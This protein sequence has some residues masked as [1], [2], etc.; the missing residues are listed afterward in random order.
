MG[1]HGSKMRPNYACLF[2]GYVEEQIAQQYTG[3]VPQL[4]K[5]Y[6]DD[7]VAASCA[8]AALNLKSTLPLTPIFIPL[9]N[10]H[11]QSLKL[12]Y[13]SWISICAFLQATASALPFT[14]KPLIHTAISTT[15]HGTP[16]T[17]K[18][19]SHT[20]SFYVFDASVLSKLNFLNRA[21][22]M[23][24]FFERL[25][26]SPQTLKRNIEKM[27]DLSQ[28]DALTKSNSTEEKMSR[29]PL[30]PTYHPSNT[31][32]QRILLDNFKV[33]ADDPATRLIFPQPPM[34]AFRRDGNLRTSLVHT[35]EK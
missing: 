28:S 11:L 27:K 31:R 15:I 2:V 19:A 33:I 30:I 24:S 7:V 9:C 35:A 18:R 1:G 26:Y 34:V 22:E 8:V 3:T 4:H 17:A 5:R 32:I 12:N 6:I 21:Q 13:H 20:A 10:S 14:T 29:I 16:A 23:A 25:G